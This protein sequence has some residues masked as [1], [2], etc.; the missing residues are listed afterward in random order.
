MSS[1]SST[2]RPV[3]LDDDLQA[4]WN[5]LSTQYDKLY[6]LLKEE[7]G[8]VEY[9]N[10]D[11]PAPKPSRGLTPAQASLVDSI[12]ND[13]EK[14]KNLKKPEPSNLPQRSE[15]ATLSKMVRDLEPLTKKL[16]EL[17]GESAVASDS[18]S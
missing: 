10:R 1:T 13:F 6:N 2:V 11:G 16:K 5:E 18:D 9:A 15:L 14:L 12:L 4:R 7:A 3:P 17:H 8:K